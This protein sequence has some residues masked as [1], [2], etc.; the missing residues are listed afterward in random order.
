[1]TLIFDVLILTLFL[2][3]SPTLQFIFVVLAGLM[4]LITTSLIHYLFQETDMVFARSLDK[5]M[6]NY[7][8]E[9][10]SLY[11]GM[12][13][14]R[15]DYHDHLQTLKAYLDQQQVKE[16]RH[17]LDDLEDKLEEVD[18]VV[19]SGNPVLDAVV[20]SKLT[21]AEK[22]NIP[23][24]VKVFVGTQPLIDDV[25]LVVIIGNLMDN[26]IE[27]ISEQATG[28]KKLLRVYIS[29]LK[30]QLY[31]SITNS[32]PDTQI[33]DPEYASTKNDKRGLGIRRINH[34]V[35]NYSGMINRQYQP[36]VFVTEIMLPLAAIH[37]EK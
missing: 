35:A 26:A 28:E 32:R 33:I 13:G 27:A 19:H 14:W 5:M 10:Q 24:N 7:T 21:L 6:T 22:L 34:L 2:V 25:D 3:V 18:P 4:T 31:I 1:M 15:H 37:A 11:E 36:G 8:Q 9:V 12:R 16:A 20:N 17:Y 23:T 29:I 30:Q